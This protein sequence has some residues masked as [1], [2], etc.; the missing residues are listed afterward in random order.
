MAKI[1]YKT[2]TIEMIISW[3]KQNNQIDWLKA[4]SNT[5]VPYKVYPRKKELKLDANGNPVLSKKGKPT[6]TSVAD[7]SAK[8]TI[9]MRK[10]S[11]V[12]IKNAFVDTF[13]PEL[14]P[15]AKEKAPTMYD[16]IDSL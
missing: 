6:Y 8:P 9:E 15:K 7:K 12:Q 4:V 13:M 1:T 14:K 5:E 10:P 2:L 11:F 16:L 3:C